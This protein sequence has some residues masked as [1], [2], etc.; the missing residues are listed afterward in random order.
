MDA[1]K[2]N[3]DD[4]LKARIRNSDLTKIQKK[5]GEYFLKIKREFIV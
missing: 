4:K 5:I 1:D 3:L 2:G